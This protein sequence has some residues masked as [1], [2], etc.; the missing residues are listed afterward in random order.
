MRRWICRTAVTLVTA[1]SAI[2]LAPAAAQAGHWGVAGWF[3]GQGACEN[4]GR[5]GE[6]RGY[7]YGWYC[8]HDPANRPPHYG[9]WKLVVHYR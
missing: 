9:P 4:S 1:A 2:A 3:W 5:I 8:Q 7:W 6:S